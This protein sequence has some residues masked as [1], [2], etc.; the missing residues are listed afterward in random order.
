MQ[1]I[2]DDEEP[3]GRPDEEVQERDAG[4]HHPLQRVGG[5][6]LLQARHRRGLTRSDTSEGV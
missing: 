6:E 1:F 3:A 5:P 2:T 4:P